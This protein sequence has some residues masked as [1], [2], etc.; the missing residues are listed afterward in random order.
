MWERTKEKERER[1][2]RERKRDINER[3]R[4]RK[5]RG[6][7][8]EKIDRKK[9]EKK[10]EKKT[11]KERGREREREQKET[12]REKIR[13]TN[14]DK[15]DRKKKKR[16]I[17]RERERER[18]N[19]RKEREKVWEIK[20]RE[21]RVRKRALNIIC[22]ARKLKS[23]SWKTHTHY[24]YANLSPDRN[25]Q[26]LSVKT[27]TLDQEFPMLFVNRVDIWLQYNQHI[28]TINKLQWTKW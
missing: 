16:K 18:E 10:R 7:N 21:K 3:D 5:I 27:K 26:C 22:Y 12:E 15:I 13:G 24:E 19:R 11:E 23:R 8:R 17:D 25:I 28:D 6:T 1:R 9:G 4:E 2:E 20:G 14:R